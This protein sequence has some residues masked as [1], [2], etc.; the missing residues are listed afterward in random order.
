M[1]KSHLILLG[2]IFFSFQAAAQQAVPGTDFTQFSLKSKKDTID[3]VVTGTNLTVK[4]PVFLFVQGS[5]PLPLF[6]DFPGQGV[7]SLSLGNF[8]LPT[9]HKQFHVV[10][11][12]MPKTPVVVGP[13]HLNEN[14]CYIPDSTKTNEISDAF[15]KADYQ[16]NY[17]DRANKVLAFLAKQKWVDNSRVVVAGHSQGSRVVAELVT[18][19][20]RITHAGLFGF[21]PLGRV[22]EQVWL[23]YKE[24]IKGNSS[25][26]DYEAKQNQ[27]LEK[28]ADAAGQSAG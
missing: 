14:Y 18:K 5:M 17:V 28:R 9:M 15:V 1:L 27:Q 7:F 25:W 24:F 19:N 10:V 4:K 12:S 23:N 20:K 16:D 8:D 3:F 21:S 22:E 26:E 11:I 6:A 2:L 13:A